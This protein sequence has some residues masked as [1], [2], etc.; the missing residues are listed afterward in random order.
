[1]SKEINWIR[2]GKE[3][4][5]MHGGVAVLRVIQAHGVTHL[6]KFSDPPG[7]GIG[8]SCSIE[9]VCDYAHKEKW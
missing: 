5:Q 3:I 4:A 8:Q 7:T 2:M 9:M 6:I 1:M